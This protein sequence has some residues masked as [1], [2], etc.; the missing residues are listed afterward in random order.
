M[1][2]NMPRKNMIAGNRQG[3][4]KGKPNGHG[5]G[6]G[7]GHEPRLLFISDATFISFSSRISII[8]DSMFSSDM[9]KSE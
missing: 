2:V 7:M 8:F 9:F 3:K 1:S 4:I 6:N 5:H